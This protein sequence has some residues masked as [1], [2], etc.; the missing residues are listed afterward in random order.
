MA[1]Q[2]STDDMLERRLAQLRATDE[3]VFM[4]V[5]FREF[6][7]PLG[8]VIHR[9]VRDREATED[10]LQDV[11][12]RVWNNR[13]SIEI[14]TT[15]RAYLYRAAMNAALR[16]QQRSA[17]SVA[18]DDAPPAAE[19]VAGD[20]LA[21]LHHADAETAVAAAL[22]QLPT[23]CRAVFEMSRFEEMS[24]REIAE[25]LEI[26]PKTVENQMGKALRILRQHLGGLLRNMYALLVLL[27]VR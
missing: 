25:T 1:H 17:R 20:S 15:W 23:Q 4:E 2:E 27:L 7:R 8:N 21:D 5:L 16:Y 3:R 12:A 22:N 9:V 6:Y 14:T 13:H 18:L 10:L 26:S 11:F 24:Y 19:P